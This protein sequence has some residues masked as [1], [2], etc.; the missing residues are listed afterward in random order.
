MASPQSGVGGTRTLG[1]ALR[2]ITATGTGVTR[3]PFIAVING[4]VLP[5]SKNDRIRWLQNLGTSPVKWLA[6]NTDNCS[7]ALFHGV[8]AAG[9][10]ED[11][12]FGG[13][14]DLHTIGER[15]TIYCAATPRVAVIRVVNPEGM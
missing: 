7:A 9:T 2:D 8:L 1:D 11:D 5:R 3:P 12:G 14:V 10:A 13:M 6:N 4:E 15:V